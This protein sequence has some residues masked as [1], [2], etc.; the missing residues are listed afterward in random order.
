MNMFK[1]D[2]GEK[3][4]GLVLDTDWIPINSHRKS[5]GNSGCC[6]SLGGL[7]GCI[8]DGSMV[9]RDC[10]HQISFKIGKAGKYK[11]SLWINGFLR[12]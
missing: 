11:G 7:N 12:I 4:T 9:T 2:E 3:G 5:K 10:M 6:V 8:G 1:T